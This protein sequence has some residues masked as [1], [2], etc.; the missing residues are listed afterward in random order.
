[1]V[2]SKVVQCTQLHTAQQAL[3]SS[4]GL[5][6]YVSCNM[7]TETLQTPSANADLS[8][9]LL[10]RTHLRRELVGLELEQEEAPVDHQ[11]L[12]KICLAA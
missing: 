8:E 9:Q 5:R 1:M 12:R 3:G 6:L 4:T 7:W 11:A 10:S 2:H